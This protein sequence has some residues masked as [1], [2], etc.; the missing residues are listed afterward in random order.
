M[1]RH[2]KEIPRPFMRIQNTCFG[3]QPVLFAAILFLFI[4]FSKSFA[5]PKPQSGPES[6]LVLTAEKQ[7]NYAETL[8]FNKD[9]L[10]AIHEYK[11]FIYFFPEDERVASAML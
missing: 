8:F 10:T 6:F 3:F 11:R 1:D 2:E 9:Y 4:P 7:F 5:G